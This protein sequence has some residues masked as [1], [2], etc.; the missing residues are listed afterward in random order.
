MNRTLRSAA[1]EM[2]TALL[3]KIELGQ[4]TPTKKQAEK[5]AKFFGFAA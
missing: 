2:D 4:R 3:S 5:L 1:V